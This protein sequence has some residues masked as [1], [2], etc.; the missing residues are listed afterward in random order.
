MPLIEK[1]LYRAQVKATVGRD[2]RTVSPDGALDLKVTGQR[3]LGGTN[4]PGTNPEQL[5]AASY[6]ASF[7]GMMRLVAEREGIALPTVTEVEASVGVGPTPRG[8]GIEVELRI[9]LPGLPRDEADLLVEK[10]HAVCP[11]S[12][13]T[14]GNVSMRLVLA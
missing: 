12:S 13:A 1:V 10:S 14:R 6:A 8:F 5:F 3:E 7:L 9:F 2:I 11:Y 4:G